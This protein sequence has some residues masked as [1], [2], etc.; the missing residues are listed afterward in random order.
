[1]QRGLAMAHRDDEVAV[2][3]EEDLAGLD[4]TQL[5]RVTDGLEHDEQRVAIALDLRPLMGDDRVLHGQLVQVELAP[6]RVEL[7]LGRLVDADPD[8]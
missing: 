4:V 8:E 6:H 7:V 1:V 5:A 2:D 3:E